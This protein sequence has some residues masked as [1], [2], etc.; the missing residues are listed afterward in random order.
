MATA[1]SA[2]SVNS[3]REIASTKA[4]EAPMHFIKR[5]GIDVPGA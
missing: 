5:H 1:P 4:C 2:N 3:M